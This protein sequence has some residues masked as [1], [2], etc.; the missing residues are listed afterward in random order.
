MLSN[1]QFYLLLISKV[2]CIMCGL[3][4]MKSMSSS[5]AQGEGSCRNTTCQRGESQSTCVSY[6]TSSLIGEKPKAAQQLDTSP[7]GADRCFSGIIQGGGV[8][9]V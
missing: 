1:S 6:R 4:S 2:S 8:T 9:G 3:K 5:V 7:R